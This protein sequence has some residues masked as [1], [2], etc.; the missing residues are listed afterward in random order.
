MPRWRL[1]IALAGRIERKTNLRRHP[2]TR[3]LDAHPAP[4]RR[5]RAAKNPF[6]SSGGDGRRRERRVRRVVSKVFSLADL[7][8]ATRRLDAHLAHPSP[9]WRWLAE[10][11]LYKSSVRDRRRRERRVR[12]VFSKVF[13][14]ADLPAAT[15]SGCPTPMDEHQGC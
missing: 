1:L 14:L 3:R 7:P 8:A 4:T 11:N 10:K 2:T 12:R 13:S 9:T 6:K 5:G 15:R